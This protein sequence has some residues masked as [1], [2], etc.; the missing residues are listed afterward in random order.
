M[1]LKKIAAALGIML[2]AVGGTAWAAGAIGSIVAADGTINGCYQ[3]NNGQLRVVA[4]G[5]ACR[6]SELALSWAQKGPQGIQGPQGVPGPQGVQGAEGP[7][8]DKGATG[9][10]GVQGE[11]GPQG[12]QGDPGAQGAK[13]EIGPQGVK[14]DPG[15]PGEPGLR[16]LPGADGKTILNGP[17]PPGA[18]G[19]AGD[20]YIDTSTSTFYGPKTDSG[21]GTGTS[22]VGPAGAGGT[23]GFADSEIVSA[24]LG[25]RSDFNQDLAV[26]CP[27]NSA[28]TMRKR[29]IAGG[30]R[31]HHQTAESEGHVFVVDSSPFSD[32]IWQGRAMEVAGNGTAALWAL[33]VWAICV[34]R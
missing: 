19:V 22:L 5:E 14:G 28:L 18:I 1:R 34:D 2:G 11:R 13:G 8:G 9:D 16:G 21:W 4:A 15:A 7:K 6:D 23:G 29:V 33:E 26:T 12:P 17:A 32:F 27:W 31:I 30:V 20:F 3:Q 24:Q 10:R 25:Y